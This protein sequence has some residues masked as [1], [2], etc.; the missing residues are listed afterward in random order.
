MLSYIMR[1]LLYAIPTVIGV[2]LLLFLLF[3]YV[4]PPDRMAQRILG[5]EVEIGPPPDLVGLTV[6]LKDKQRRAPAPALPA[7]SSTCST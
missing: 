6:R 1:R 5:E 3:F 7:S 2:V 4:N